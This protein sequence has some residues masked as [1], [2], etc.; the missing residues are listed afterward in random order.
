VR[1][2]AEDRKQLK[3]NG[4]ATEEIAYIIQKLNLDLE[5]IRR[6]LREYGK[7]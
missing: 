3:G 4:E 1:E 2:H 5:E 7:I 6:E